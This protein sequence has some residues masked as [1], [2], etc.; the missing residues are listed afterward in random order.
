MQEG[1]RILK[2]VLSM[3]EHPRKLGARRDS[4]GPLRV[5][6]LNRDGYLEQA[7]DQGEQLDGSCPGDTKGMSDKLV[8]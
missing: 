6:G 4:V 7:G 2:N 3:K 1:V 8:G 5:C